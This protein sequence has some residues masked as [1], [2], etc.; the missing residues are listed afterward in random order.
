MAIC[1]LAGLDAAQHMWRPMHI[2]LAKLIF[3]IFFG[4]FGF[5]VGG[6]TLARNLHYVSVV[7]AA[8]GG[9]DRDPQESLKS[10]IF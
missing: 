10:H 1:L 7:P 8:L 6:S 9:N 4:C 3:F 2:R 5:C